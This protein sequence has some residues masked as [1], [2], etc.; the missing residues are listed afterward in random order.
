MLL[1]VITFQLN[2]AISSSQTESRINLLNETKLYLWLWRN[3]ATSKPV[4]NFSEFCPGRVAYGYGYAE[5]QDNTKLP[6]GVSHLSHDLRQL[7]VIQ[8][9]LLL[10]SPSAAHRGHNLFRSTHD[11]P[12]IHKKLHALRTSVNHHG[13][14]ACQVHN[15]SVN[16]VFFVSNVHTTASG[17]I[18]RSTKNCWRV[19]SLLYQHFD[20]T[21]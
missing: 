3:Q 16:R 11:A 7:A 14:G 1:F 12:T 18:W 4:G 17:A 5:A 8:G 2:V 21:L 9:R 15:C 10:H 6:G 19:K 20:V 13:H